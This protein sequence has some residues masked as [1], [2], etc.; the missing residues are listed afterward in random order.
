MIHLFLLIFFDQI[1][2]FMR[3]KNLDLVFAMDC[4]GSMGEYIESATQNIYSIVGEFITG[5][6]RIALVEYRDHP[7]QV[8]SYE[9]R[10]IR[11]SCS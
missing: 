6:I 1:N 5:D 10:D 11:Y 8:R 3:I 9:G 7:L 4:T 2:Y